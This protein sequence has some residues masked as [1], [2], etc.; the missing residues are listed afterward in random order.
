MYVHQRSK[1]R[2]CSPS[3]CRR[4]IPS[5]PSEI[6]HPNSNLAQEICHWVNQLEDGGWSHIYMTDKIYDPNSANPAHHNPW[7]AIPTYW[8]DLA[9][10]VSFFLNLFVFGSCVASPNGKS[11]I[12]RQQPSTPNQLPYR[13]GSS[14]ILF[15][16]CF[17]SRNGSSLVE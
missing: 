15:V 13:E 9:K 4:T 3:P 14:G 8:A 2:S 12:P 7:D 16:P 11:T 1:Q 10:A 5:L 17:R 6:G